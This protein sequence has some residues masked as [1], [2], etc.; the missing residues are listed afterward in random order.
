MT[1]LLPRAAGRGV[2]TTLKPS[3]TG[4]LARHTA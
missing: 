3:Q 1:L 2:E 4:Q